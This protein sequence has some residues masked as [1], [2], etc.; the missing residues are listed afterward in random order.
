M[1][2]SARVADL[3][4]EE[5]T[6]LVRQAVREALLETQPAPPSPPGKRPPLDLPVDNVGPWPE[7]LS[8]RR[9]DW[10]GDDER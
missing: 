10:Y 8:L 7:G 4:V 6:K 5:L 9:E 3:T 1:A 2:E